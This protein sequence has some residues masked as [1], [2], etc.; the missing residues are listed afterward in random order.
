[1]DS[2]IGILF[3]DWFA[4]LK[5][6]K[7][8]IHPKHLLKVLFITFRSFIN[9][10]DHKKEIQQFESLIQKTEIE[11]DPVFII[12]HW[13]SGTTFLHYLLS[14]DKHFA[15][16]NVFEG[17]NPHTFLSNQALLEKRLE[18]YKPQ[19]RVMD[20]VSVQLIS[21]AEDEFAMAIIA[22]KSPLLGWLFPQNRDYYDRYISFETV[23]EEELNYWKN[24]Y[25]YFIKKLTLKYKRQLLLKSPINTARIR[26]LLNIFPKAKFIHIHRNPYDVF[27]SSLK[28][29]NT[30][31]R[32]SELTNSSLQNF[33]EYILS[34]YKKNV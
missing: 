32:N 13:R 26:H 28:L 7:F 29:F 1:M 4:L 3:R 23:P 31:V 15:F 19:K 8:K 11:H 30:A 12:G 9:S 18:R 10:R 16:T 21:P 33:E 5:K 24:R 17:R 2:I 14:Q 25:L 20:N 34:H 6:H 27:R 22:L